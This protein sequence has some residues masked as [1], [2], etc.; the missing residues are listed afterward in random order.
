MLG[1]GAA[2]H[3][4]YFPI[5][6][7]QAVNEIAFQYYKRGPGAGFSPDTPIGPRLYCAEINNYSVTPR[8]PSS[9]VISDLNQ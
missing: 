1:D 4:H 5:T 3:F 8:I 6:F 2:V 9:K 7:E